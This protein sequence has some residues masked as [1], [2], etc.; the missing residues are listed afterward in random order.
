[1]AYQLGE[2]VLAPRA[3]RKGPSLQQ[4]APQEAVYYLTLPGEGKGP[5]SLPVRAIYQ[6]PEEIDGNT[7]T[8]ISGAKMTAIEVPYEDLL[9]PTTPFL[10]QRYVT[11]RR[12]NQDLEW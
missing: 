4:K 3:Q 8:A 2:N 5:R 6:Y 11:L 12:T 1:M 10:P 9:L 7:L